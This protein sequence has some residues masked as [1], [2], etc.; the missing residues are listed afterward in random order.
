MGTRTQSIL[1]WSMMAG[2]LLA[3]ASLPAKERR[4]A[5]VVVQRSDGSEIRGELL[6]VKRDCLVVGEQD[7]GEIV[8]LADVSSVRIVRRSKCGYGFLFGLIGGTF[9]GREL[10]RQGSDLDA[11]SNFKIS[12]AFVGLPF[13]LL[14]AGIGLL[15]GA[16]LI[17]DP[18][19]WE[20]EAYL[21]E[22]N[23]YARVP[24]AALSSGQK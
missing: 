15:I 16:D 22:L 4:G 9:L 1:A 24:D 8:D 23:R 12:I 5:Q 13:A 19:E 10:A 6:M 2:L 7:K 3:S 20:S 18:G 21:A 17:R 14:G 11:R